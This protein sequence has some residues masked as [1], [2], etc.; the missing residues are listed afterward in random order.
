MQK[1]WK[2]NQSSPFFVLYSMVNEVLYFKNIY[3]FWIV[4]KYKTLFTIE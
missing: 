2:N 4:V 3:D 1:E